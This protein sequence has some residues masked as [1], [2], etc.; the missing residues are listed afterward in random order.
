VENLKKDY[1][2]WLKYHFFLRHSRIGTSHKYS[3]IWTK[4]IDPNIWGIRVISDVK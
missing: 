2:L 3:G 4:L 1:G